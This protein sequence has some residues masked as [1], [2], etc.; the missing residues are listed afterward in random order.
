MIFPRESARDASNTAGDNENWRDQVASRVN[1][2]R[3]RRGRKLEG[4][5]SMR[6]D[7]EP[8]PE[9]HD[10]VRQPIPADPLPD[11][12]FE[13]TAVAD[14]ADLSFLDAV[15]PVSPV[16]VQDPPAPDWNALAAKVED[17]STNVIEFPRSS[18][19]MPVY[20]IAEPML[21]RPRILDVPEQPVYPTISGPLFADLSFSDLTPQEAPQEVYGP[22]V[23]IATVQQRVLA[24]VV[25]ASLVA[26]GVVMFLVVVLRFMSLFPPA[27]DLAV[28]TA[29]A[30]FSVWIA[31]EY[32]FLV[33]GAATPG[34]R[35]FKLRLVN[36][37]GETAQRT[38][39]RNRS[40]AL[41][42]S[43]LSL[44]AGFLWAFAD[45]DTL[46]WHDRMS[47]TY[48]SH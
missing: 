8:M 9:R 47:Q 31:Y 1:S 44:F 39:R 37:S 27:R 42:I 17:A 45:E 29:T 5:F 43:G 6:F 30:V 2:Y 40:V 33:H 34:M 24:A 14:E 12:S 38:Q 19:L 26:I 32:L 36:F 13:M 35:M 48:L 3:E 28:L 16:P 11:I 46:C 10:P 21:D 15:E 25:D 4:E 22:P 23:P 18:T 41:V 7:F 20:E